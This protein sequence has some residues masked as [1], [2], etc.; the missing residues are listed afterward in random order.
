MY[1]L[2]GLG[3]PGI[4]YNNTRHNIGFMV[5]DELFSL[6][7][8]EHGFTKFKLNKKLLA[9][10][11]TGKLG[12]KKIILVKPQTYMN[13]S[14]QAVQLLKKYYKIR[15]KNIWV[16]HDDIDLPL[17]ILRIR[18]QGSAGGH[19]GIKSMIENLKTEEFVRFRLGIK[20]DDN[21]QVSNAAKFVLQKFPKK[22]QQ[23]VINIIDKAA[24]AI[25]TALKDGVDIAMNL[26][27]TWPRYAEKNA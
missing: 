13:N 16:I 7:Q 12:A 20:P 19:N 9:E 25:E 21:D 24:L 14:G 3:N 2:I 8:K 26:H 5:L 10:I 1:L 4:K 11:S 22:D 27:N 23:V 18:Q 17:G 6:W 15:P